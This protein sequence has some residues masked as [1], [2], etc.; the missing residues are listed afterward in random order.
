ME[1]VS[2]PTI[3]LRLVD[4][5]GQ[6]NQGRVEI[7][8]NGTWGTVCDDMFDTKAAGIV[9]A[10]AGFSRYVWRNKEGPTQRPIFSGMIIHCT[11]QSILVVLLE[12]ELLQKQDPSL[13]GG[14]VRFYWTMSIVWDPRRPSFSVPQNPLGRTTVTMTKMWGSFVMPVSSIVVTEITSYSVVFLVRVGLQYPGLIIKAT[15][16]FSLSL[17]LSLSAQRH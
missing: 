1:S 16:Q 13:V 15:K 17:S 10:M 6:P 3:P 11:C 12:R 8:V 7:Q 5:N 4:P 9:C 14:L 2:A